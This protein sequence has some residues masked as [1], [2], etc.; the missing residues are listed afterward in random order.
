MTTKLVF[1]I[2]RIRELHRVWNR[3]TK[4]FLCLG[5]NYGQPHPLLLHERDLESVDWASMSKKWDNATETELRNF[6]KFQR[7]VTDEVYGSSMSTPLEM[8][9]ELQVPQQEEE[10]FEEY[11]YE[12]VNNVR[13]EL[14]E[15]DAEV[16]NM[17]S[18]D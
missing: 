11:F 14:E 4:R 15:A 13:L 2:D 10:L 17:P 7:F 6:V 9:R 1:S 8:A 5:I 18:T 16:A 12:C 3:E